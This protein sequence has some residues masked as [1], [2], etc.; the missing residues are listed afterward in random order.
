[1]RR[2]TPYALTPKTS[3]GAA[4]GEKDFTANVGAPTQLTD[5]NVIEIQ[6]YQKPQTA[7]PQA[8]EVGS[9]WQIKARFSGSAAASADVFVT[10]WC[11]DRTSAQ[12][13]AIAAQRFVGTSLLGTVDLGNAKDM[14]AVL[15]TSHVGFE[16]AGL[17]TNQTLHLAM[18]EAGR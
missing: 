6:E 15:G 1:M 7:T 8:Y 3:G 2:E 11:Y 9:T 4:T 18:Y 13:Y 12:W 10:V 14:S 17:L 5:P 16:V